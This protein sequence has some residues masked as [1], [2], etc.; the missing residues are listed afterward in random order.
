MRA[1][2]LQ[3][4]PTL[5][6]MVLHPIFEGCLHS[7]TPLPKLFSDSIIVL[8]HK[9]GCTLQ[10][11][12]YRP[13]ALLNVIAKL[14][15]KIHNDRLRNVIASIIPPEQTWFIPDRSITENIILLQ[16]AIFYAK[17]HNPSAINLSLDF[18]KAYDR[19][20]WNVMTAVLKK[21]NF[22]PRWMTL[23]SALY[24]LRDARLSINGD[25]S[26]R[27]T[28]QRGVL[29][30]DPLSPAFLI[31]TCS[32]LSAML[33]RNQRRHGIPLPDGKYAPVA[34]FYADDTNILA[35]SPESAVFLYNTA[36][37][38]CR[39]SGAKL[40]PHKCVA[41]PTGTAP[42]TL[43]NGVRVLRP[44]QHTSLLGI[45]M[46]MNITRCQQTEKVIMHMIR[47]CH[48]W[49]HVGRTIEGRVTITRSIILSTLWY[50]LSALSI[51]GAET[52]KIQTAI[53]KYVKGNV[54]VEWNGPT[55]TGNM[56]SA[57]ITYPKNKGGWGLETVIRTLKTRK[58]AL[59]KR[60]LEDKAKGL[61]K[62]WHTF[63]PAMLGE[64]VNGW[65][66]NWQGIFFWR[67]NHKHGGFGLGNWAAVSPWWRD[68]WQIWLDLKCTPSPNSL[69]R[70][71]LL[72][73]PVWN[74]RIMTTKHGLKSTLHGAFTNSETR[75]HMT[76]IRRQGF[77]NFED[78]IQDNGALLS[79]DDLYNKL[80]ICLSVNQEEHII[81]RSAC[82]TLMRLLS[83]LWSNTVK[84]WERTSSHQT[85][86]RNIAWW[87]QKGGN[88]SFTS[89]SN[90]GLSNMLIALEA[91]LKP[92]KLIKLH[93]QPIT[94]CWK[95]ES[96]LLR[97]LAPSR[98]DLMRRLIRN[99]LP[100]GFKRTHWDTAAQTQCMLCDSD[101]VESAK[102]LFWECTFARSTWGNLTSP[103]RNHHLA[104][105]NWKEAL[106]GYEVRLNQ[107]CNKIV[108]QLW[109]IVRSCTIRTIWFERNRRYFYPN[110]P[111]RSATFRH[112]QS[113]DDIKVHVESWLR[114]AK[115]QEK[116][117]LTVAVL[118]LMTEGGAYDMIDTNP[119][120]T[121]LQ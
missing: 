19:I 73:W 27:F 66:K 63:A 25:L 35:R 41:I 48:G 119:I 107:S 96:A 30:G 69:S 78:F 43:S 62:P 58:L 20:Q 53:I 92:L 121:H 14:L 64:H 75:T 22:G 74:N 51:D 111:T 76:V 104:A 29:Q 7:T 67:G 61:E 112:N 68:A 100:L 71:Q 115:N 116:E 81:P 118:N 120:T 24:R 105:V 99:A 38:F 45:P 85:P 70:Q 88:T 91:P 2:L 55:K 39:L 18:E 98:R 16:D 4:T 101:V 33:S 77:L 90:R 10:P 13:I 8:L 86:Q 110:L 49:G 47:K 23:I 65:C 95:R 59:I 103:W 15:T 46:G 9:K 87:P 117:T 3:E 60:F 83:A 113:K 26:N 80:L 17:R 94:V 40:H 6:A 36:S 5:W 32:P 54:E 11:C 37:L 89:S 50:I 108:E 34:C 82:A 28:I 42:P 21:M 97:N 12:N 31:L 93:Q 44:D 72:K 79:I 109:T 84:K 52:K 56:A 102:H 114:R 1:E 106:T 57:W